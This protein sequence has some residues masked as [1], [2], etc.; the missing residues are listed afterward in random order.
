MVG[1]EYVIYQKV[2]YVLDPFYFKQNNENMR[3]NV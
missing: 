1:Y 2:N 3:K